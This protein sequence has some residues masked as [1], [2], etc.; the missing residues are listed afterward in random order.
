MPEKNREQNANRKINN[1][2]SRNEFT[3]SPYLNNF[4]DSTR[5]G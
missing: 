3:P 2:E 5:V 4:D 1:N